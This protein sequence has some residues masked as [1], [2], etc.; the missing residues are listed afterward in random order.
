M[1]SQTLVWFIIW[2]II[3]LIVA[4]II[5]VT[6]LFGRRSIRD[7]PNEAVVF[8]KTGLHIQK[9]FKAKLSI[10]SNKGQAFVYGNNKITFNPIKYKEHYFC[11]RR[12]IFITHAGQL[13]ASPFSDDIALSETEKEDLIYEM[14]ASHVG[15]DGMRALKGKS[16]TSILIIALV[17]FVIGIAAVIGFNAFQGQMAKQQAPSSQQQ[18]IQ[19]VEVE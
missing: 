13:V 3:L 17:A 5:L 12:M 11:E 18:I 2:F 7:K 10:T 1:T 19:P 6:F 4:G 16:T 14:C 8:V 9:P 15:A